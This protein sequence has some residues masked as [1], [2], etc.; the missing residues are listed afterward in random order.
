MMWKKQKTTVTATT[1]MESTELM[2]NM[3]FVANVVVDFPIVI[4]FKGDEFD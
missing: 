3:E 1:G 2:D 4:V